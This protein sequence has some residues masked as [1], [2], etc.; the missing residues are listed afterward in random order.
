MSGQYTGLRDMI[1]GGGAGQ[2]GPEFQ[3]GG[4]YSDI[5][6]MFAEPLGSQDRQRQRQAPGDPMQA[7]FAPVQ[8]MFTTTRPPQPAPPPMRPQA[9]PQ[10]A[11]TAPPPVSSQ[12][13]Q[14]PAIMLADQILNSYPPEVAERMAS[15][16]NALRWVMDNYNKAAGR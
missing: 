1:D 7:Q 13:L 9:R 10:P 2:V 12:P 3:G 14:S 4:V 16:P 15:D 8:P 11:F 5:A 6:N